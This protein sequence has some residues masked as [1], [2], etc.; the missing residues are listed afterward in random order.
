MLQLL[1]AIFTIIGFVVVASR[2]ILRFTNPA[3]SNTAIKILRYLA[4]GASRIETKTTVTVTQPATI[5]STITTTPPSI[6]K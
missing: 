1:Q 5:V 3:S 2:I 6:T 4:T